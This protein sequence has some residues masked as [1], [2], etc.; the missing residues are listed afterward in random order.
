M[1]LSTAVDLTR[2]LVRQ[3]TINPPGNEER[4]AAL[5]AARLEDNGFAVTTVGFGAGRA[6]LVARI[7]GR[8]GA[9]PLAFTGHIDTVPLGMRAWSVDPFGGEID[10]DRLYGRGSSD[11]KAGVAAF[12]EACIAHRA[13]LEAGAGA[14]LIITAAEE[15]GCEGA[16]HLCRQPD[17]LGRAGALVVAEPTSNRP[18]VGHK[19]ALWL[20]AVAEGVTA[21]GSMP[22][23]G[24]N[25]VAKAAR[26]VARLDDFDFN[27]RRHEVLGA[28][29]LNVGTFHGGINVNSVPDRAEV[30]LDVRTV[31]GQR[32]GRVREALGAFLGPEVAIAPTVDVEAVWTDPLDP[33]MRRV[34]RIMTPLLGEAPAVQGATYFTDASALTP[35]LGGLPTVIL[36]PGEAA[37][38]HQTDEY[39]LVSRIDQAVEAYGRI[40]EDW[41]AP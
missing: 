18:L 37:M 22:E 12:V 4:C 32:H 9:L 20:T 21:H 39:C 36:G 16:Y 7:G 13:T 34:F 40:I 2:A 35:A 5:L 10:G 38:A 19:G 41:H 28:P 26:A 1:T 6:S 24:V 30:G 27:E 14:L 33:W 11:M 29:T 3:D 8:D 17:L 15:T 31:P 23:R 25:A